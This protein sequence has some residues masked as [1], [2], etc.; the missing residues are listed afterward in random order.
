MV[1]VFSMGVCMKS[2]VSEGL[3]GVWDGGGGEVL[4]YGPAGSGKTYGV[5]EF[6]IRMML[7][8]PGFRVLFTG[9]EGRRGMRESQEWQ[10]CEIAGIGRRM[11][12]VYEFGDSS[13][14]FGG[15]WEGGWEVEEFDM[16]V[17]SGGAE[18]NPI[19]PAKRWAEWERQERRWLGAVCGSAPGLRGVGGRPALAVVETCPGPSDHW[20][21][22]RCDAGLMARV[23]VG[24]A[25]NP[26]ITEKYLSMLQTLDRD[27][28]AGEVDGIWAPRN[29]V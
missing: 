1:G 17:L 29:P 21:K 8:E 27:L 4:V 10:F 11:D 24:H 25:D 13:W 5:M 20:L 6:G 18:K 26:K 3:L 12:G 28:Y 23:E 9:Y 2:K 14:R 16:V 19:D 7:E 15:F 22:G